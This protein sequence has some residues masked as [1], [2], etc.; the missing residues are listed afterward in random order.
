MICSSKP[1]LRASRQIRP[2]H[3]IRISLHHLRG[4]RGRPGTGGSANSKALTSPPIS[5]RQQALEIIRACPS[6]HWQE[7]PRPGNSHRRRETRKRYFDSKPDPADPDSAGQLR[8]QRA[9]R[10][11]V[12][13]HLHRS[14]HPRHHASHLRIPPGKRST[15]PLFMGKDTHA[16]STSRSRPRSKCW[17]PTAWKPSSSRITASPHPRHLARH[18]D[19]QSW[20]RKRVWPTASSSLLRTIRRKMAGFKYNPPDGGPADT[21]VTT[22][23]RTAP[24]KYCAAETATCKRIPYDARSN[25]HHARAGFRRA[26]CGRSRATSSTWMPFARLA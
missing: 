13:R 23:F 10:H 21:D 6:A 15:G 24:T 14:P 19:L 12:E 18:S 1:R 9:S 20:P 11:L 3:G 8:H 4:T 26:L 2:R 22:G 17:P 5:L 7:S 16:L 25:R